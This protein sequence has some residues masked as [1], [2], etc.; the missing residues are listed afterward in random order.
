MQPPPSPA[1]ILRRSGGRFHL[2]LGRRVH[3]EYCSRDRV[4]TGMCAHEPQGRSSGVSREQYSRCAR[5][6]RDDAQRSGSWCGI[7]A[8]AR[9]A[10]EA[11]RGDRADRA[12]RGGRCARGGWR[13]RVDLGGASAATSSSSQALIARG[14]DTNAVNDY[15]VTA[16][17]AAAVEADPAIVKAL[18]EAGADVE[19]PNPE[20]QTALMVVARTG[21]VDTAKLLLERGANVNAR[22]TFGGQTALMWAAA[23]KH[24]AMIRLLIAH[25][26]EVDARGLDA[27]LGAA[28]DGRAAHQDHADRRLHAAAVRRARGLRRVRRA[29]RRGRCRRRSCPIRSA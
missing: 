10:R 15:G 1:A 5:R 25:G 26:A 3:R 12:G 8:G 7:T 16:L 22:E 9:R 21:R 28:R 11:R 2:R 6:T 13:D 23:Q 20:G 29:A 24:P 27:R 14:A 18:L 4:R 17:A 19:S